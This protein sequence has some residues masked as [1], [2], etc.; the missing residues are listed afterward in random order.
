MIITDISKLR[1]KCEKAL[2]DEVESIINEL[3]KAL[4]LSSQKG[5][6]GI[7]L[8]APQI[9]INKRVAIVRIGDIKINLVNCGIYQRFGKIKFTEGCLSIP[10][11]DSE[12]ERSY[13]VFVENNNFGSHNKFCAYGITGVCV[14]HEMD[15]WDGILM[16]DREKSKEINIG[17]NQPCPCGKKDSK[18]GKPKKYKK[19]CG[20]K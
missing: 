4:K 14:Q 5:K 2:E 10:N 17:P 16:V 13:Q 18:T 9:G 1:N 6:P 15:H 20:R 8:A 12:V 19:C 3:D 11:V 7:G